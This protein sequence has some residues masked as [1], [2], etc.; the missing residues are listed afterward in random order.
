MS[1]ASLT[2]PTSDAL[3]PAGGAGGWML[4]LASLPHAGPLPSTARV[5]ANR[6][7]L[8]TNL[9]LDY[10]TR[11]ASTGMVAQ[12]AL[13]DS[14]PLWRPRGAGVQCEGGSADPWFE[15]VDSPPRLLMPFSVASL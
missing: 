4:S 11:P 7:A 1:P 3:S 12:R 2:L 8:A 5:R 13:S 15:V 9:I 10:G 6:V 14:R